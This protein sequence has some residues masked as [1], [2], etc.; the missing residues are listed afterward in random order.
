MKFLI[1]STQTVSD[2]SDNKNI[3]RLMMDILQLADRYSILR[4]E[5]VSI[6][7]LELKISKSN[8]LDAFYY[9]DKMKYVLRKT[10]FK[11]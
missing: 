6:Q 7:C 10:S 1:F 4:L 2:E 5:I 8:V 9:A 3:V 11:G